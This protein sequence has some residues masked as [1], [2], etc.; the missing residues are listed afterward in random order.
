MSLNSQ[1]ARA[2][3]FT[4]AR[5]HKYGAKRTTIDGIVFPSAKEAGRYAELHMLEAAGD[6]AQLEVDARSP[7]RYALDVNNIRV[8]VYR[9]DFRYR[10]RGQV[11]CEDCKGYVTPIFRLKSKLFKACFPDTEL[12]IT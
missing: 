9:P 5:G 7:I 10:E 11:I 2:L 8:A 12:R 6:I 3:G 4:T 1:L